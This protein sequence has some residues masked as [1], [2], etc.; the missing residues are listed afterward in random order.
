MRSKKHKEISVKEFTKTADSF[1]DSKRNPAEN[2]RSPTTHTVHF[3]KSE[4]IIITS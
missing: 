2:I 4:I 3:C 1:L